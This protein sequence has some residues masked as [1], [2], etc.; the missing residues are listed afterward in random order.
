MKLSS[1]HYKQSNYHL[2]NLLL[3]VLVLLLIFYLKTD[4]SL[5]KCPYAEIGLKCKTCGLTTS[6]RNIIDGNIKQI[7]LGHLLFFLLFALQL[8]IRPLISLIILFSNK[9]KLIRNIDIGF[10]MVFAIV[11]FFFLLK[12]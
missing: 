11:A 10:N 4:I 7:E 9:L 2:F 8:F 5:I 3:F 12:G 1:T 6:F